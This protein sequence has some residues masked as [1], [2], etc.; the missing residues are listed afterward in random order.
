MHSSGYFYIII[1]LLIPALVGSQSNSSDS[2]ARSSLD[3][4]LQQYA[5]RELTWQRTRTGVPYDAYVPSNLMGIKVSAVILKRHTLKRR[6][7]G[8]YKE[9]FIPS[10]IIVEPYV[11]KL[12]LVYQNLGNWSSFYYPLPGYIYLTPVLGIL[13][14][15]ANDLYAT[16]L[17]ELD[18]LALEDPITIRFPFVQPAP[19]GSFPK[20]AYFY[21][22][23]F[24]KFG[25]VTDGNICETRIQGHYS[26]VAEVKASPSPPPS[27][28]E[29]SPSPSA[30]AHEIAP[31]PSPS[32]HEI[33][34]SP[35]PSAHEIAPSPPPTADDN[36]HQ[37]INSKMW[38]ISSVFLFFALLGIL[39]V[40]V[41]KSGLL[42]IKQRL[43]DSAAVVQ[44][45]LGNTEVPLEAPTR[46][47]PEND[48]VL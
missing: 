7:Y 5:F 12:V 11:K 16:N 23:N 13:A 1:W 20:C 33:A 46:P 35:S 47:L 25:H 44:P 9:F 3:S 29:I 41:K 2:S 37:N 32:A 27:A 8:Y 21:S 15:D 30:S 22:N 40:I 38:T 36:N 42:E 43:Y 28:H 31:S 18:I 24:V 4:L 45:L 39:F 48:Y 6:V 26:I 10:G 19:E 14:Y 34:P 17:P